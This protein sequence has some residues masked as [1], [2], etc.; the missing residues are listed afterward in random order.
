MRAKVS[1]GEMA[2]VNF[3]GRDVPVEDDQLKMALLKVADLKRGLDG[4]RESEGTDVEG[5]ADVDAKFMTLLIGFD[6]AATIAA[7]DVKDYQAMKVGPAVN[8]RRFDAECLLGYVK[9]EKLR[10]LMRRNEK[11]VNKLREKECSSDVTSA[12]IEDAAKHV[13]EIAHLYDA[14]LQDARAIVELPGGPSGEGGNIDEEDEFALEATADV[15]RIRALRCYYVAQLYAMDSVGKYAEAAALFKH[16]NSL[17]SRAAEEV[18]ACHD[19][20]NAD[21]IIES[22][23]DLEGDIEAAECRA[24][25]CAYLAQCRDNGGTES[26]KKIHGGIL[27]RLD[28]FDAV[29]S[30]PTDLAQAPPTPDYVAC[31]PT[32][33]DIAYNYVG[34]YPT[35][36]LK[37]L[38]DVHRQQKRGGLLSWFSRS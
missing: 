28:D 35:E 18:S 25:A 1:K 8:A 36:E 37:R 11:M 13:E 6:D 38:A 27:R 24:R 12:V 2:L 20:E 29:V 9:Y 16:S 17:A 15:L 32:F 14:L 5:D 7:E 10:L 3:R 30:D 19:M 26:S 34:E 4:A 23:V 31:K 33:F 22:M 21:E